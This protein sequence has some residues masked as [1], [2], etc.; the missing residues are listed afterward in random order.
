MP[1]I[2]FL[3]IQVNQACNLSCKGCSTFSDLKWHGYYTWEEGKSWLKPWINKI[4]LPAIGYMGG[5]PLLNPT[6]KDWIKGVHKMLPYS[7]QRFVTNGT[8]LQRHWD[9]FH[10]LRDIGN[11]VFKITYHISTLALDNAIDRIMNEY[12]WEPIHEYGID[13]WIERKTNFRFQINKPD[14]FVQVFKNDYQDM[15]PFN[16][17]PIEAFNACCQ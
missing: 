6:I 9:V 1:T 10:L 7:Q 8:L 11:T 17:N 13:R 14:T 12:E 5:E 2:P 15:A 4:E 3:E 16:N